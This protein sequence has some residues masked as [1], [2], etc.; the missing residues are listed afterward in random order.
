MRIDRVL[1]SPA[2]QYH[3]TA[4]DCYSRHTTVVPYAGFEISHSKSSKS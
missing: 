1:F 2:F 3:L 4:F